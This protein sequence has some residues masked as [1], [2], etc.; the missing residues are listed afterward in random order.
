[1]ASP[2]LLHELNSLKLEYEDYQAQSK[3][4]E[5]ALEQ[6]LEE[7][8][9]KLEE[10]SSKYNKSSQDLENLKKKYQQIEAETVRYQLE[11]EKMKKQVD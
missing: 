9:R 2:D 11:I 6:E 3:E 5:L 8:D 1:M 4:L 7:K 10:L